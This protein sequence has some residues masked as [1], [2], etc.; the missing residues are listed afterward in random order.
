MVRKA[1]LWNLTV[2]GYGHTVTAVERKSGGTLSLYWWD[3]SRRKRCWR[4]LG[5]RDR[6]LAEKQARELSGELLSASFV[7]RAPKVTVVELLSRY[8]VVVVQFKKKEHAAD[9]RRRIE[10]WQHFLGNREAR[11]IDFPTIDKF[12]RERKAGAI[13]VPGLTR[14]NKPRKLSKHPSATT[15]GAD[16]VFLQ[17]VFNWALKVI[18]PDGSR[19]LNENPIRGYE[20]PKNKNPK[21]PLATYDRFLK[22]RGKADEADPQRLFGSFLD[23]IE[24]LGWRV[25]AICQLQRTDVDRATDDDAPYGRIR[26]RG[27]TDKEGVD[28]WL[29]LTKSTRE[30]VD[31]VLERN[32]VIGD[33][34]LFPARKTRRVDRPG[35]WTRFYARDL[36]A[37]AEKLAKLTPIEGGDF[38]PYRR[39]WSTERKNLPTADVAHA[40]GW[41]DLRSLERSYQK[42]D[43]ATVLRVMSEPTKVRDRGRSA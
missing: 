40:G 39:K 42:S 19:L 24:G 21:Q 27:D 41:R 22:V 35:P 12:V 23:L 13:A 43:P 14:F 20:R 37:R 7:V 15:V 34:F 36:L 5:H 10:I 2:G 28:A 16:I 25:S 30:A 1:K 18:L 9:D 31:R 6:D 11:T 32:P 29:P 8:E 3:T 38:H 33:L 17:S 4:A 26:K